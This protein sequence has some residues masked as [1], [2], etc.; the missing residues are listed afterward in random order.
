MT[1]P[2]AELPVGNRSARLFWAFA[3]GMLTVACAI[4]LGAVLSPPYG[5]IALVACGGSAYAAWSLRRLDGM[6]EPSEPVSSS[7]SA[8]D[9]QEFLMPNWR[10]IWFETF[11]ILAFFLP[12]LA[13]G[14][15]TPILVGVL[16]G[17]IVVACA[18][19]IRVVRRWL[20]DT[21]DVRR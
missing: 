19:E 20:R 13:L 7:A 6:V 3:A 2:R 21:R 4:F 12:A 18:I 11:F 9:H 17:C 15:S 5:L 14:A 1:E 10:R 16:V 8:P